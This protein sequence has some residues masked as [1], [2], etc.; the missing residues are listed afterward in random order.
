MPT[1]RAL[2]TAMMSL[3]GQS[4]RPKTGSLTVLFALTMLLS[5]ALL[6]FIQ[7][8]FTKLVL[9]RFGGTPAVWNT[10]LVF[11]QA[12][13]LAGYLYAH[14][15]NT[16]LRV[17]QQVMLHAVVLLLPLATLPIAVAQDWEPPSEANP[18][19]WLLG[20]LAVQVGL[21]FFVVSTSAPLLQ[22][23]FVRSGHAAAKDPYFLYAASNLG[24]LGILVAYPLVLEPSLSLRTQSLV[25]ACGYV[26]LIVLVLVCGTIAWCVQKREGTSGHE[27]ATTT[28]PSASVTFW[29][30]LHWTALAIVPASLMLSV[31]L[32]LTADIASIPLLWVIPLALYLLTFVLAFARWQVLPLGV[33]ARIM[34]LL[35]IALVLLLVSE[36]THPVWLLMLVHLT[37]F[38]VAALVCHGELARIRPPASHL[39]E[40]YLWVSVGGVVG[41]LLTTLVAP[42]LFHSVAEYPLALV[43]A[44]LLRPAPATAASV[45]VA[46]SSALRFFRRVPPAYLD[47]LLPLALAMLT[48]LLVTASSYSGLSS[49]LRMAVA[50]G[51]PLVICYLFLFRPVRFGI[52][53]AVLLLAAQ[54][55][56]SVH[57]DVLHSERSFFGIHR[58]TLDSTGNFVQLVHGSTVHGVQ[59]LVHPAAESALGMAGAVASDRSPEP[60]TYY[61][62]SGP[63]GQVFSLPRIDET[64]P[65]VAIVGLGAGSLASYVAAGQQVDFYEID[66]VVRRIAE[67]GRYFAFLK[68]C[69]GEWRVIMGDARLKLA[70]SADKRY[71]LIVIDAFNS[72]AVPL[73]L[74]TREALTLYLKKLAVGGVIACNV[75]NRYLELQPVLAD[76]AHELGLVCLSCSDLH[77]T[78]QER[79]LGK[80]PSIWV[81][82]ASRTDDVEPLADDWRW[83]QLFGRPNVAPWTDDYANVL[84]AFKWE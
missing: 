4:D 78:A 60:L 7:P 80:A 32:Y 48:F 12:T 43:A 31:T 41:G 68:Q 9:P 1:V 54:F 24:S 40:F 8:L 57:G 34:P 61:Y 47:L 73:H 69:P 20:L 27:G 29:T 66:P 49:P 72:D 64:K 3:S 16:R 26:A 70:Q 84:G 58:V 82:L 67:D 5:A 76:L 30:R 52:G 56:T 10:C 35:V 59:R 2:Y 77:V 75:S 14:V 42:L 39:T 33:M 38:F 21:P 19:P 63:I 37:T 74:M 36:A 79:Q 17:R 13:L 83:Q 23:W 71:G 22:S 45:G 44:C 50:F 53:I 15:V 28:V 62:R 81:V 55:Q 65:P 18:V 25:W 46:S 11:F 51:L 6:F